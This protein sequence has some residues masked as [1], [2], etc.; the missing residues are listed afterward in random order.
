M[1][2]L[3]FLAVLAFF[4]NEAM[5]NTTKL[6][7]AAREQTLSPVTYDGSYRRIPY[8]MGDVPADRG[9]CTD[10]VIRAY[11]TIGIDLQVLVHEDMLANFGLYP[12]IWGLSTPDTNIDHRRVPNLQ[13]FLARAGAKLGSTRS[14]DG[15]MPGDLVTWMLPGNLPHIGI[16]SDR[17]AADTNRPLVIHN[18]GAGPKEE[19]MLLAHPITGHYRYRVR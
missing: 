15:Y 8:P 2:P 12:K 6:V 4:A 1:K 3:H 5:A 13:S 10:V 16:V 17:R 9:V 19:D 18:I 14:M 11:R 7:N